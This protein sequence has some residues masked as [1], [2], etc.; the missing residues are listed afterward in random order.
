M[1]LFRTNG[2]AQN[3]KLKAQE[4]LQTQNFNNRPVNI[5]LFGHLSLDIPLSFEL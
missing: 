1:E 4:K 3:S 2:K 5:G